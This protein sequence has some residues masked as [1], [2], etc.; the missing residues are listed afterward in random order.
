MDGIKKPKILTI[1]VTYNG[2]KWVDK[3]FS[4]LRKSSIPLD[5]LVVDNGSTD[6]TIDNLKTNYPE[7]ELIESKDNLGFGKANNI[8][9]N[10][11][12][13]K[14]FD[15]A[16]LLNQ[17]AW[18]E[19]DTIKKLLEVYTINNF[20]IISPIQLSG[21]GDSIDLN[22]QN[23]LAP[24]MVK[25]FIS[26]LLLNKLKPFY[27]TRYTNAASWLVTRKCI[28]MVGVFDPLFD[29]YGEDDD[30]VTRLHKSGLK[31][32]LVP[33]SRIFHDRPQ[34]LKRSPLF[35]KNENYILALKQAK[36]NKNISKTFLVRRIL[37]NYF[38]LYF[39]SLGKNAKIKS[40][41]AIDKLTFNLLKNHKNK[42]S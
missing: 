40:E 17:D 33:K 10:R 35:Y 42:F 22:F 30:Y 25:G 19:K 36:H 14:D 3:C 9:L 2:N 8:G 39:T 6:G 5:V 7:V 20:G 12:L 28:E 27:V 41:I 4:S 24:H 32:G 26:D 38:F 37:A 29:H 16:F 31:M 18:V 15:F 13:E 11:V 1:I 21:T 23:Y 34:D